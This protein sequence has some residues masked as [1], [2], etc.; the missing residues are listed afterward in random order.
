MGVK[1]VFDNNQKVGKT[2]LISGTID[3]LLKQRIICWIDWVF[4]E[5][6]YK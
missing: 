3:H 4:I 1:S 5:T 2:Y 6:T